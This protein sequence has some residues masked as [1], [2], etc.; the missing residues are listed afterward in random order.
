MKK[1][2]TALLV[3]FAFSC[4][5]V[6]KIGNK[7]E[8]DAEKAGNEAVEEGKKDAAEAIK[9]DVFKTLLTNPDYATFAGMIETAELTDTLTGVGPF[10]IFAPNN[11]AFEDLSEGVIDNLM[12]PESKDELRKL[13][14]Y[15][16]LVGKMMAA[17]MNAKDAVTLATDTAAILK[18]EDGTITYAGGN[19]SAVDIDCTNGVIHG[20]DSVVMPGGPKA[21]PADPA[22]EETK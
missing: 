9:V 22:A 3:M 12:K 4:G 14:S 13:L 5:T 16:I 21:V 7:L 15:H 11:K 8:N 2:L 18:A 1:L 20:L 19:V 6:N 17:D 10:T